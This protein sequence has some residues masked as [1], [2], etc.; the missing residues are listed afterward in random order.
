VLAGGDREALLEAADQLS[1]ELGYAEGK[2]LPG[3]DSTLGG[4]GAM[5]GILNTED[6]LLVAGVRRGLAKVA[7]AL[8]GEDL[9]GGTSGRAVRAA[10]DGAEMAMRGELVRGKAEQLPAMMPSFVLLVALTVADQDR[11]LELSRRT[12]ELLERAE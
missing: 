12:E 5:A 9:E 4:D 10:L 1:V 6:E 3:A 2:K 11:A 8:G 7:A